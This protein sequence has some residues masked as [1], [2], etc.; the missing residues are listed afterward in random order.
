VNP[1]RV[2]IAAVR[3]GNRY[4]LQ[5]RAKDARHFPGLWEFPGGK[6]EPGES[7]GM[8]L[9]RE[10][11]EETEWAPDWM[12]SLPVLWYSYPGLRV[13]LNPFLCEGAGRPVTELAWGWFTLAEMAALS[14]PDAS[15]HVLPFLE[16]LQ[17]RAN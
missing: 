1:L 2:S 17:G 3:C 8:A 6:V 4:F 11:E 10:L 7:P 9:L 15:R 12:E 5:R 14:M 13:E 16:R